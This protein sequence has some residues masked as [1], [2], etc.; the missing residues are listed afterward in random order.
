MS[1]PF[2]FIIGCLSVF[3]V[4]EL[5]VIDNGPWEVFKKLRNLFPEGSSMD[6]LLECFFCQSGYWSIVIVFLTHL[7]LCFTWPIAILWWLGIWGGAVVVYR[8]VPCRK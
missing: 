3:R 6:N 8:V 1:I 7:V 5:F 4:S 2:L